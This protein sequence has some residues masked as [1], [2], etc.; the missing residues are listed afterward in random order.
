MSRFIVATKTLR[1]NLLP[2]Q[3]HRDVVAASAIERG[4]GGQV[5]DVYVDI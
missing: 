4:E 3:Q 5:V 1:S 2:H